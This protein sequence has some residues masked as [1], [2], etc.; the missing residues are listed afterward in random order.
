MEL[1]FIEKNVQLKYL[2][3]GNKSNTQTYM[4]LTYLLFEMT[5]QVKI[6][7]GTVTKGLNILNK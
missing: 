6:K 4:K 2:N 3:N 5:T 7:K 1:L